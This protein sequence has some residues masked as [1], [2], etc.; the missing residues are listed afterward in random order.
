M[1]GDPENPS[2]RTTGFGVD[3]AP[4]HDRDQASLLLATPRYRNSLK[5]KPIRHPGD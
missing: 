3:I 5:M 2:G 4:R 1:A